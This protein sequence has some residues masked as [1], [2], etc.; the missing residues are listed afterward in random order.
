MK[1]PLRS[2]GF[3]GS[4]KSLGFLRLQ[5]VLG[6]GLLFALSTNALANSLIEEQSLAYQAYQQKDYEQALSA[7]QQVES[8]EGLMGL[9]AAAYRLAELE[10]AIDSFRQ[11]AWLAPS[12]D[13]RAEALF[14][15]GNSYFQGDLA[16]FA[17]EAY[18]QALRYR[19]DFPQA[20]HNLKL[21]LQKLQQKQNQQRR[22]GEAEQGE[23]GEQGVGQGAGERE[24][25][26]NMNQQF[27]GGA[28]EENDQESDKKDA[29]KFV[30]PQQQDRA[31]WQL[32]DHESFESR[33]AKEK[34]ASIAQ[35]NIDRLR[36]EKFA[37]QLQD[38]DLQQQELLQRLLEREEGFH[39]RQAEPHNIPGV[40]PW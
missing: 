40:E 14:N 8:V 2:L 6:I 39:A 11:A 32:A 30:L 29:E 21:A 33:R 24:G 16:P 20:E 35:A 7:Y 26:L 9:G 10:L 23:E 37:L 18:Q 17:V 25:K 1:S 28:G 22:N 27:I 13:Q 12:D 15:L 38:L 4:V 19:S 36:A 3:L 34:K 5:W 31:E